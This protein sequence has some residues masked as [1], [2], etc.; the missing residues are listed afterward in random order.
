MTSA[1]MSNNI[2]DPNI[3]NRGMA[4]INFVLGDM[5]VL[6]LFVAI[7]YGTRVWVKPMLANSGLLSGELGH[8]AWC[9]LDLL[10]KL[11]IWHSFSSSIP[12]IEGEKA[13][14]I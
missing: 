11:I 13:R 9:A 5:K 2:L 7:D 1:T 8:S 10:T 3:L 6:V 12:N 14:G 4:V